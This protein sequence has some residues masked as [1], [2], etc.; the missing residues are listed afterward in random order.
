MCRLGGHMFPQ[1]GGEL[2]RMQGQGLSAGGTGGRT[3]CRCDERQLRRLDGEAD[4]VGDE[5]RLSTRGC[6]CCP[7][8]GMNPPALLIG[9]AAKAGSRASA[10]ELRSV[11]M[12]QLGV[13]TFFSWHENTNKLNR[14]RGLGRGISLP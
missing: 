5:E 11:A 6:C 8:T 13:C 12:F 4:R 7:A 14:G 2:G 3:G 1:G 9:S 10:V